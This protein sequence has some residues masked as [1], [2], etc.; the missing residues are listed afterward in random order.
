MFVF[1]TS[2]T[3]KLILSYITEPVKCLNISFRHWTV[4]YTAFLTA[5]MKPVIR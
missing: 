5:G 3:N 2:K 4:N 1:G